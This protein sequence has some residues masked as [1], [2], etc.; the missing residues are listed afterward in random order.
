MNSASG[1][2]KPIG[3]KGLNLPSGE[4]WISLKDEIN[5]VAVC[6]DWYDGKGW[7]GPPG[8][9]DQETKINNAIKTK[10]P[11]DCGLYDM[12]G[13]V[14]EW[15]FE[16]YYYD[17]KKEKDYFL[18]KSNAGHG[19]NYRGGDETHV[20]SLTVGS[21]SYNESCD[22]PLSVGFRLCKTR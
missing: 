19:R 17:P 3:Y 6:R 16:M 11:N 15:V 13:N 12:S 7:Y 5:R 21:R 10:A 20:R 14:S 22:I 9:R 8:F 4:T 18:K 2:D 1:A